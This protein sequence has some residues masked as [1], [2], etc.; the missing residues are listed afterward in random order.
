DICYPHRLETQ[1]NYLIKYQKKVVFSWVNFIN[2]N[3]QIITD[4]HFAENLFNHPN[5]TKSEILRHFFFKGNYINA[6]TGFICRELLFDAGLFNVAAIQLQDFEMWLKLIKKH[7]I[8]ILPDQLIKY[9]I[10]TIGENLSHPSNFIRTDFEDQQIYRRMFDD[11][12][13]ELFKEAF[14]DKVIKSKFSDGIEYE[15]EKAFLYLQHNSSSVQII[16]CEKLFNLLQDKNILSCSI[17][18]Y[19]FTLVDL[20]QLTN[21]IDFLNKKILNI[22]HNNFLLKEQQLENANYEIKRTFDFLAT[23][24][25]FFNFKP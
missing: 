9:R 13:K 20:Y 21:K 3:S 18:K 24:P 17:S 4:S 19:N 14:P 10:R 15:L 8:Y 11:V 2:E 5:R 22:I 23:K 6:V 12:P 7:E 1:Y 25:Y 16:G